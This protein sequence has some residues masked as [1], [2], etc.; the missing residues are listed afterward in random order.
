[1]WKCESQATGPLDR[2]FGLVIRDSDAATKHS[3]ISNSAITLSFGAAPNGIGSLFSA[4]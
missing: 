4:S 3:L 1:M 2:V